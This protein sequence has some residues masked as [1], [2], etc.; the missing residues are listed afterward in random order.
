MGQCLNPSIKP[1]QYIVERMENEKKKIP[2]PPNQQ[3]SRD[4]RKIKTD[5]EFR[6][7]E[8][9]SWFPHI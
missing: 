3:P 2:N 7:A 6:K 4:L 5:K 1:M 8:T 9:Y